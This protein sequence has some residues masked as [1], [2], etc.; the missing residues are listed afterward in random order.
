MGKK[1]GQIVV[2]VCISH[3][4]PQAP[5]QADALRPA[6]RHAGRKVVDALPISRNC[7]KT[8]S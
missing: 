4:Q 6:D 5:Q 7:T 2:V 3:Q 1:V 8:A